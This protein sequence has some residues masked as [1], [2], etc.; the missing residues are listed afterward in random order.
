MRPVISD[1]PGRLAST[2]VALPNEPSALRVT[3]TKA[4]PLSVVATRS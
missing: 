3:L 1:V 4:G 2:Q